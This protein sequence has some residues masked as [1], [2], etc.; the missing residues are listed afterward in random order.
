MTMTPDELAQQR[1]DDDAERLR[2]IRDAWRE[3]ELKEEEE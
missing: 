3:A 1:R 2:D